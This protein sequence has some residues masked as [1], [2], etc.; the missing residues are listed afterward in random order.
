MSR[1]RISPP[2]A[3]SCLILVIVGIVAGQLV[4]RDGDDPPVS[5]DAREADSS[6]ELAEE[7]QSDPAGP[8]TETTVSTTTTTLTTSSEVTEPP[9]ESPPPTT[10]EGDASGDEGNATTSE[11][12]SNT[13]PGAVPTT[14][15]S[16]QVQTSPS[17]DITPTS[18]TPQEGAQCGGRNG[19]MLDEQNP[20]RGYRF[21]GTAEDAYVLVVLHGDFEQTLDNLQDLC[22]SSL[23][24]KS[25]LI[26]SELATVWEEFSTPEAVGRGAVFIGLGE[27]WSQQ[28]L[29]QVCGAGRAEAVGVILSYPPEVE[30][31]NFAGT[32]Q[33]KPRR[34]ATHVSSDSARAAVAAYLGC[35]SLDDCPSLGSYNNRESSLSAIVALELPKL[36][37]PNEGE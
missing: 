30:S 15:T 29:T 13:E 23:Q 33:A 8:D 1:F 12:T 22:G 16:G 34:T 11:T 10:S 6:E 37:R 31:F 32:C 28:T 5:I 36:D 14:P 7:G 2:T 17:T 35:A 24:Y 18:A 4:G 27:T 19:Q 21:P 3:I 9:P 20:R 25:L 26:S